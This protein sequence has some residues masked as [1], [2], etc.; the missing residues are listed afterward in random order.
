MKRL[1]PLLILI[2]LPPAATAQK[3]DSFLRDLDAFF[4]MRSIK[5]YAKLDSTYIKRYPNV[6][7]ARLYGN[8]A[9]MHIVSEGLGYV[10]LSTGWN[11]RTGVSLGYRGLA[12]SYSVALGRKM[13][14]D[15]NLSTFGRLGI[16][17][18]LRATS[19]LQGPINLEGIPVKEAGEGDLTLL[20]SNVNVFFCFNKNFSYAAAIKQSDIQRRS[21]GSFIAATSWIMWDILGAGP[22]IISRQ[23]SLQ[24]LLDTPNFFYNRV[25]IGCGYGYNLVLGQEHWLLHGSFIPMWSFLENS[26]RLLDGESIKV[27]YPAGRLAFVGTMRSGVYYRWGTRWSIGLS[28]VL[29]QMVTTNSI[30]REKAEYQ[31]YGAQDWQARLSLAFRF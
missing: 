27:K 11:T 29:N 6:W 2:L 31:R 16:D 14:F 5:S 13:N 8:T 12:L 23:T 26:I 25:S 19:R 17:F 20:A 7:D 18:T 9:G 10:S 3:R 30:K 21:A 24:T 22:D 15:L 28:G 4:E 1:L